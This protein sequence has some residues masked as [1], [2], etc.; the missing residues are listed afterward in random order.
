MTKDAWLCD[1]EGERNTALHLINRHNDMIYMRLQRVKEKQD[2][3]NND[4][5]KY[6]SIKTFLY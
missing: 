5:D 3:R 1:R 2:V 4:V 6:C